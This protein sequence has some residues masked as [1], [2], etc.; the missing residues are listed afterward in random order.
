LL[1]A[2]ALKKENHDK[3]GHYT[4]GCEGVHLIQEWC[5]QKRFKKSKTHG[6]VSETL[7]YS[8]PHWMVWDASRRGD[9]L[10]DQKT[11]HPPAAM[12]MLRGELLVYNYLHI[13][14]D[15]IYMIQQ[16]LLGQMGIAQKLNFDLLLELEQSKCFM[17]KISNILT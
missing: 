16:A 9:G 17:F 3:E 5:H 4:S 7:E 11:W 2:T 1:P 14:M 12:H 13:L 15:A 6:W 10:L 8:G